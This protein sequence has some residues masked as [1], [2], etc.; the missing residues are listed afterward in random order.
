MIDLQNYSF[1][2]TLKKSILKNKSGFKTT[3]L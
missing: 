1:N 3:I 2:L